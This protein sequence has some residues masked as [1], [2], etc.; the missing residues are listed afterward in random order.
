MLILF[1]L[2]TQKLFYF[3]KFRFSK[4]QIYTYIGEVLIAV[5]PYREL[6]L[7][8]DDIIQKYKNRELYEREPHVF[9]IAD[10]I[11]RR[12]ERHSQDTCI[13]ISGYFFILFT[14][15]SLIAC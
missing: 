7:Y 3:G 8:N 5:N 2:Y 4:N 11:Y 13:V 6:P 14:V 15:L 12:M 10:A 1:F 9:A